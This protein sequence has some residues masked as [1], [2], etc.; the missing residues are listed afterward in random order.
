MALGADRAVV[1]GLVIRQTLILMGAGVL[2]G[3]GLALWSTRLLRAFL[4]GVS[5]SDAW[6]MGLAVV[7]L[8]GCG[9]MAA[10]VPA[11]RAASVNP[12]E[13]LRAD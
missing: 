8:V 7:A 1:M 11:R 10:V 4:Y 9:L 13:A 5:Q 12:V 6:T 3:I 2:I